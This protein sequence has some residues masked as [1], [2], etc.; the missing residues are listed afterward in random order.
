[1]SWLSD[2]TI[3]HLRAIADEPDLGGTR[4]RLLGGI[5]RGGMAT[6]YEAE[7]TSLGRHVAIKVLSAI[8][9]D[10]S[11]AERMLREARI[12]ATLEHPGIVPV[13]DVGRLPD[14]RVFY[15]MKR[16]RG[17]RLD[18]YSHAATRE[19]RLRIV[20][21]IGEA[22][23]FAHARGVLHRD[24][25]PENVMVGEFGE[26]LVMDW[27][28]AKVLAEAE[29]TGPPASPLPSPDSEFTA[30]GT[31]LG[32]PGWMAPE[33]AS[34]DIVRIDR[35]AD[36]YGLGAILHYLLYQQ[37]PQAHIKRGDLPRPLYAILLRAL[38]PD[39][40]RRYASVADLAADITAFQAG[41]RVAAYRENL[42]EQ[43]LRVATK[44]RAPIAIVLS[45]IAM[46]ILFEIL[47]R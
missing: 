9:T 31:R 10:G 32:T 47:R 46:R 36:V 40:Q 20:Q 19:E 1:M 12:L 23:A 17:Q 33:Q 15:V 24:L 35:R 7:D 25:K 38:D 28:V 41:T 27:G 14:G 29:T 44:Y 6:V 43:A 13:H 4:Y 18:Q 11:L 39:P 5:G 16:V 26:V 8:D 3:A 2:R 30:H 21:R 37:P 22:V 34:G 45:Y 42:A